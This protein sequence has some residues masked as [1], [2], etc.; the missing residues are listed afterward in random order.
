MGTTASERLA[1][2]L[3]LSDDELLHVLGTGA[4]E[5]LS[6][7]ADELPQVAILLALLNEAEERVGAPVLRRWLRTTG[8]AGDAPVSC[9]W[10]AT[11]RLSRIA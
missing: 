2:L 6:G 7:D 1:R 3:D 9:S 4:L 11:S 5:V 8:P 10:R